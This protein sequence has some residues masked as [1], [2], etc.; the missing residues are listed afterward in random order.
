MDH[1]LTPDGRYIVV[2]GRLWRVANPHLPPDQRE[3]LVHA[4]MGARREVKAALSSDD[5]ERLAQARRAVDAAKTALGERGSVW[6]QDGAKDWNRYLVKNTP[7][8]DWYDQLGG[9]RG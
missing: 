7:Y 1:P 3:A 9:L 4:L 5:P 8:R 2:R 6:W